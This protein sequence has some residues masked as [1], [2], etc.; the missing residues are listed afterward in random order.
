M[1]LMNRVDPFGQ[2]FA[3][4]ARGL[5]FGNRGGRFHRDDRTLGL[6]RWV[7]RTW[8]CCRLEF[9]GRHREVWGKGYTELFFLDEP[10]ALAA[11][12]RPCFECRRAD[13]RAFAAAFAAGRG[14]R[15][16]PCAPEI[17]RVL[18][19][20]RLDGR[21]KRRHRL[22]IDIL[23]DGAFL[24]LA[25]EPGRALA[26]RG[27]TLLQWTPAG[28]VAPRTRPRGIVADALTPPGILAALSAGYRPR[29][30]LSADLPTAR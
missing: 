24:E 27:V 9:K 13:A 25:D 23:P 17:D 28:Y 6:R 30:H 29:W 1:P 14:D 18:H 21:A 11:G 20:E 2:P 5:F 3:D 8:I 10:T 19:S 15:A 7:S 26:V 12:H 4:R 22:P 16:V